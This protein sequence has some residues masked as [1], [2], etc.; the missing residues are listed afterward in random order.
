VVDARVAQDVAQLLDRHVR[1]A[2]AAKRALRGPDGL[3]DCDKLFLHNTQ[4]R[5]S[6]Q[7]PARSVPAARR[8]IEEPARATQQIACARSL[9]IA[10]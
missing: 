9:R 8:I 10:L 1:L 5:E 2:A 6:K 7:R 3:E 4:L